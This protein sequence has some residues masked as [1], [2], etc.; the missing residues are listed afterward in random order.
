MS[1]A[2]ALVTADG[3]QSRNHNITERFGLE[4]LKD[5]LVSTLLPWAET[6]I[7]LASG[8][9]IT[10]TEFYNLDSAILK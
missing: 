10:A 8:T 2:Q 1:E 6:F 9:V 7:I 3:L 5:H 4:G